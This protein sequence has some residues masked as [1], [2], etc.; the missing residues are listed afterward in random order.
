MYVRW[1]SHF[2]AHVKNAEG[3]WDVIPYFESYTSKVF[4]YSDIKQEES[5]L[6]GDTEAGVLLAAYRDFRVMV[7]KVRPLE[8]HIDGDLQLSYDDCVFEMLSWWGRDADNPE[9]IKITPCYMMDIFM[10]VTT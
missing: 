7:D 10:G 3:K 4:D 2:E 1:K 9:W 5:I 8:T 6:A